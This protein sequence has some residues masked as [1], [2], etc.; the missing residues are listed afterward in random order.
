MQLWL[1]I[2]FLLLGFLIGSFKIVSEHL[3]KVTGF[4]T[5]G[6][7]FILLLTMGA[8][9]GAD[10]QIISRIDQIGYQ[11]FMLALSVIL[12]SIIPVKLFSNY[13]RIE[14]K[15]T[16]AEKGVKA[17]KEENN[18]E[19]RLTYFIIISV[20]SGIIVGLYLIT[21]VLFALLDLFT[22]IALAVL[23]LGVGIDLGRKR[24][25]FRQATFGWKLVLI[26]LLVAG[27]SL[28]GA[29][30]AGSLLGLTCQEAAAVG[31]GFGWYSLSAI[32]I[33]QL[34]SVELASVAFLTNIFRELITIMILPL[35]A[36]YRGSVTSIAPGGA[37]T[38]DVTLPLIKNA[39]GEEAVIPALL[40][41]MI[42][43][44][45]VPLLVPLLLKL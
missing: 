15:V 4:L 2:L 11:S 40:N 41:G 9:I 30:I 3:F 18:G 1:I 26:P 6:G 17:K 28:L 35:T 24:E 8:K 33:G 13:W 14:V 20:F 10:Q 34:Y 22:T 37:T 42:L 12:G 29:V 44:S 7:L 25:L 45:L 32:L 5:Q 36:K 31:A 38:M 27:G 39:A 21:P 23:L 16:E 19:V 43:S